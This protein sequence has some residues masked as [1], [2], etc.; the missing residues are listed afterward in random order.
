MKFFLTILFCVF[1]KYFCQNG[2]PQQFFAVI[3]YTSPLPYEFKTGVQQLL[4]DYKNLRTRFDIEG[5]RAKQN[6]TY[7]L[8][9]KPKGA[10]QGSPASDGYTLFNFNPDYPQFTK[11]PPLSDFGPIPYS[12]SDNGGQLTMKAWFPLPS[13]L[14]SKGE[15]WVPELQLNAVRYDSPTICDLKKSRIGKVPCLSYFETKDGTRPVQTIVAR[16]GV[17]DFQNDEYTVGMYL[18]FTNGIP[19]SAESMFDL[20]DEWPSYCGNANAGYS[21]EPTRGFVVT[22]DG[23][24]N[25]TLKLTTPLVHSLGDSVTISFKANPSQYYNGTQCAE[26]SGEGG[27]RTIVFNSKNW[28]EPQNI[29]MSFKGNYGC[30]SYRIIGEGGGYD[31]LYSQDGYTFVVYACNGISGWGCQGKEPCGQ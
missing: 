15:V 18:A 12:W 13:D 2:F 3:N 8:E 27:S 5:W 25:F 20:P 19:S 24:D 23:N 11:T 22:P 14:I 21:T 31:W 26:F 30:C 10:E 29:T 9:Y 28:N 4:Y 16:A 6:E 17:G 7:L 1:G